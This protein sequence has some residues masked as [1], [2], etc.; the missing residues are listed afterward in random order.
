MI[1][2]SALPKGV[3]T[4]LLGDTKLVR[5]LTAHLTAQEV[6]TMQDIRLSEFNKN[7]HINQQKVLV[8]DNN[9][10]KYDIILG[11][12]FLSKTVI[13]LNCSER[14]MKWFDCSIPLCPPGGLDPKEFDAMEDMFHNQV[15]EKILGED[16]LECFAT[17]IMDAKYEKTDAAEVVK[18][19]THLN[20]HQKAD[21]L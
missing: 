3:I 7:R 2:R 21:L 8:F 15:K 14:N 4:K 6:V 1:K 12:K 20:A 17:E 5:T 18:G 10:V 11:T 16:W 13:G 9:N 19:L